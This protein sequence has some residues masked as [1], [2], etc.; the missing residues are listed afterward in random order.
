MKIGKKIFL[1]LFIGLFLFGY[2]SFALDN[3]DKE[4]YVFGDKVLSIVTQEAS[5]DVYNTMFTQ[6]EN[7]NIH[8]SLIFVLNNEQTF[9]VSVNMDE[10]E[11]IQVQGAENLINALQNL[12][13]ISQQVQKQM[14][15]YEK[16]YATT[17]KSKI[18]C[19][20]GWAQLIWGIITH[21][22]GKI[23]RGLYNIA[24]GCY[25]HCI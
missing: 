8:V 7:N 4:I 6:D 16:Q 19:A 17:K 3:G 21:D 11:N 24:C 18:Q 12:P 14:N 15:Y 9:I 23:L 20:W 13:E 5:L 25:N 2:A 10:N 22:W 1:S